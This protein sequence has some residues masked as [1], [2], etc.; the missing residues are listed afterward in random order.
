[1]LFGLLSRDL[2][3]YFITHCFFRKE[4]IKQEGIDWLASVQMCPHAVVTTN[5]SSGSI[6][7]CLTGSNNLLDASEMY[8]LSFL[9]VQLLCL[10]PRL[11]RLNSSSLV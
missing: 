5:G 8:I 10:D 3:E 6:G 9:S 4:K 2:K 11:R 7:L 1:M